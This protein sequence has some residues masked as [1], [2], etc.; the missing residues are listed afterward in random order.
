[1]VELSGIGIW[2]VDD[3]FKTTWV[4][5]RM[6]DILGYSTDQMMGRPIDDFIDQFHRNEALSLKQ[7]RLSG[8]ADVHEF[9]F[10][11]I[12]GST[13]WTIASCAPIPD[14]NGDIKGCIALNTNIT[15]R[16]QQELRERLQSQLMEI[17]AHDLPLPEALDRL[18]Q[19]AADSLPLAR[20]GLVGLTPPIRP[21]C[22]SLLALSR[23]SHLSSSEADDRQLIAQIP[24]PV[25][26][27]EIPAPGPNLLPG[28]LFNHLVCETET[29]TTELRIISRSNPPH[30]SQHR[31]QILNIV[32]AAI[33]LVLSRSRTLEELKN[34]KA[35]PEE[36][37]AIRT[38]D[39][40]RKASA[41]EA[42]QEGMAILK[43]N[44]YVYI[45]AAHAALYGYSPSELIGKS[46]TTLYDPDEATRISN[47]AIPVLR[48]VGSWSGETR[49]RRR[50]GSSFDTEINLTLS[51]SGDLICCCRDISQRLSQSRALLRS[52]EQLSLVLESSR[53]GFWDWNMQTDELYFSPRWKEM[54][55][56]G[57]E[58]LPPGFETW[59]QLL[60][61][62]DEASV[63][64]AVQENLI[65]GKAPYEVE[66]RLRDKSGYWNWILSRGRVVSRDP[67]GRPIRAVGTHTDVQS[68]RSKQERLHRQGRILQSISE[69]QRRFLECVTPAQV[70]EQLLATILEVADS[71]Y[72]FIAETLVEDGRP[73]MRTHAITNISWNAET[74]R[75]FQAAQTTAFEFRNLNTLFGCVLTTRQVVIANDAPSDPRSG[76]IPPGHPPLNRFLGIPVFSGPDLVGIIGIANRPEPYDLD[77]LNE[78]EPLTQ[79][80]GSLVISLRRQHDRAQAEAKLQHQTHALIESNADLKKAAQGHD[81]F[82]ASISH[83]LRT[84]LASILALTE[85]LRDPSGQP[86]DE[87]HLHSIMLIEE[88]SRYLL[89]LINDIL[90]VARLEARLIP[91]QI[92][93]CSVPDII[94]SCVRLLRNQAQ[95]RRIQLHIGHPSP[96]LLV[97][98]DPL[99]L[100][101]ILTNLLTN[102]IKFTPAGGEVSLAIS[103]TPESVSFS[104]SD[105]GIG[106]PAE[107]I[108]LLFQPFVQVESGLDRRY[109]GTGLGL[110]IVKSFTDLMNGSLSVESMPHVGSRFTV[111]LPAAPP[112]PNLAL[113]TPP[114]N[115]NPIIPDPPSNPI[116]LL[117]AEDNDLNRSILSTYLSTRGFN[118]V[119]V[120]NGFDAVR[121]HSASPA[122]IILLDIQMPEM[123]GLKVA[124]RIRD[125]P[126]PAIANT[127][128]IALTALAMPGD[129]ERCLAVGISEYIRK[130]FSLADLAKLLRSIELPAPDP[131]SLP[132]KPVTNPRGVTQQPNECEMNI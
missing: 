21:T 42:T 132:V 59:N 115:S 41:L 87:P 92:Q 19:L 33:R 34:H 121:H 9:C 49:G 50:D 23:S 72:G 46:W 118:I 66:F 51:S 81:E 123:D 103:P 5:V 73:F 55:G 107:K 106:I 78:L 82:L 98:A 131:T 70:F 75:L 47:T 68:R 102:A 91:V 25:P 86:I 2:K 38:L 97:L 39:S 64:K 74:E 3:S 4:N 127:P 32:A 12:N 93:L 13:V 63:Q 67:D 110:A 24:N 11:H 128:I 85:I 18:V 15:E 83:E 60:H 94:N 95:K 58:E 61:P 48:D 125:N 99:R 44:H 114:P 105:T 112:Y 111:S 10:R 129:R 104:V 6:A 119:A 30:D 88:S 20:V 40:S 29:Q 8:L 7:R 108:P 120:D 52:Q 35:N 77:L 28:I 36:L 100:K 43:D 37:V 122:D 124:R 117:I 89:Q 96:T 56:Y 45:N 53:D 101:Q 62:D 54:L 14:P 1:L 26:Q 31:E 57:P 65:G 16:K 17:V 76:G 27:A 22:A 109:T 126:D 69:V 84:P 79:T 90:E 130:P 80:Y 71:R 116:R 113:P